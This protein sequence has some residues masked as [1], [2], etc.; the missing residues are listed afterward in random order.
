MNTQYDNAVWAML[1]EAATGP[2]LPEDIDPEPG[3]PEAYF[4]AGIRDGIADARRALAEL[5]AALAMANGHEAEE[6]AFD[7]L[8][9]AA[10]RIEVGVT[11]RGVLARAAMAD[12]AA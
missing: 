1:D 3:H 11:G 6:W 2:T 10:V 8:Q 12:A 4:G 7:A 9:D 5:E